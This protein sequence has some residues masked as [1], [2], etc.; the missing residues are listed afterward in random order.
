MG[1]ESREEVVREIK[2]N[3]DNPRRVLL[4][5]TV[6]LLQS[7]ACGR[8]W[9]ESRWRHGCPPV[10]FLPFPNRAPVK[11][12]QSATQ[13]PVVGGFQ[14][15]RLCE[16]S[17]LPP[18]TTTEVRSR[19]PQPPV[20]LCALPTAARR[21]H[22]R[23]ASCTE[24][25]IGL[26]GAGLLFMVLGMMMFFDKGLLAM[27]NVRRVTSGPRLDIAAVL[28]SRLPASPPA[29]PVPCGCH[30][31]HRHEQ[32]LPFLLPE[33]QAQ[34]WERAPPERADS[35]LAI[36]RGPQH[37]SRGSPPTLRSLPP[38]TA[39]FLGGIGL[40]L[41]GWPVIGMGVEGFG[42]LNLFGCTEPA[43]S[44]SPSPSPAPAPAPLAARL[45]ARGK[46]ARA[47]RATASR[48]RWW[49]SRG[50]AGGVRCFAVKARVVAAAKRS[51][52]PPRLPRLP[53]ATFSRLR[54][55]SC[56]TCRWSA[57]CSTCLSSVPCARARPRRA[58]PRNGDIRSCVLRR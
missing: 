50:E 28:R 35:R 6:H 41:L 27:G 29:D 56:A 13:Q 7:L 26:T 32:D 20:E 44:P 16:G 52:A 22:V 42:F 8:E 43:P 51:F 31:D 23:L 14:P 17:Q 38:G 58:T 34:R 30:D 48:C 45:A 54:L 9:H 55:A 40:V 18:W 21:P 49:A 57:R 5:S 47:Q 37:R 15:T 36:S 33:T 39:C 1:P 3:D 12:L 10:L 2:K 11:E 53:A 46:A 24:I 25:G 19:S 4:S